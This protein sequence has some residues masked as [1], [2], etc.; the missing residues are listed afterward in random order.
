VG[1]NRVSQLQR[2]PTDTEASESD[3]DPYESGNDSPASAPRR[4]NRVSSMPTSPQ[5]GYL[6][7]VEEMIDFDLMKRRTK[8]KTSSKLDRPSVQKGRQW[9]VRVVLFP[10]F[11]H[12]WHAKLQL[13]WLVVALLTYVLQLSA[14]YVYLIYPPEVFQSV[15]YM[16]IRSPILVLFVVAGMLGQCAAVS[17]AISRA[18]KLERETDNESSLDRIKSPNQDDL[19][20]R[21]SDRSKK[22]P[23]RI[24]RSASSTGLKYDQVN[25]ASSSDEE[26]DDDDDDDDD[27]ALSTGS[28]S[29]N[30]K[31]LITPGRKRMPARTGTAPPMMVSPR[32]PGSPQSTSVRSLI[33]SGIEPQN[34]E[35]SLEEVRD[36]I[37]KRIDDKAADRKGSVL[38]IIFPL[39]IAGG[40]IL[41]RFFNNFSPALCWLARET[42]AR[43][44]FDELLLNVSMICSEGPGPISDP[45]NITL[46]SDSD[47]CIWS[48]DDERVCAPSFLAALVEGV[49]RSLFDTQGS[50]LEVLYAS[51]FITIASFLSSTFM[52]IVFFRF[53]TLAEHAFFRR[54]LY[55]KYFSILT[56][57]RRASK[58]HLPHF[59]LNTVNHIRVW[60]S[61]RSDPREAHNSQY[62]FGDAA[63]NVLVVTTLSSVTIV[64]LRLFG[65]TWDP[66][67]MADLVLFLSAAILSSRMYRFI[68]LAR[69]TKKKYDISK[70]LYTEQLNLYI[71]I[72]NNP[73]NK[74]ELVACNNMLKICLKL[75][76]DMESGGGKDKYKVLL[77]NPFIYNLLRVTILSALGTMSSDFLGFKIRLWK[78]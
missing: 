15:T 56:S 75:I 41:F 74:E 12:F 11:L 30:G 17:S 31:K 23:V 19:N 50:S 62:K 46:V 47:V 73:T 39:L 25:T 57:S 18:L 48:T 13:R 55:A 65:G 71:K 69:R 40:P 20:E 29:V 26:N 51:Y 5:Q 59:R 33:W 49:Q 53:V 68:D 35:L 76:K 60:L 61:L 77:L 72:F 43:T 9:F 52:L 58:A 16:E 1:L 45:N 32:G 8:I 6:G 44:I 2:K 10:L 22:N 66:E 63:A 34:C 7:I 3:M 38:D 24:Q 28:A 27:D 14:T 78:L 42:S 21:S 37:Y 70:V 67:N 36:L 4:L 54:L 64:C